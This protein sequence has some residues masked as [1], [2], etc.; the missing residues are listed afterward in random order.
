MRDDISLSE[1]YEVL[2]HL[3]TILCL[4]DIKRAVDGSW[5][6]K[7]YHK[8]DHA[9]HLLPAIRMMTTDFSDIVQKHV[10]KTTYNK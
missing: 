10:K 4:F 5:G 3:E 8:L 2:D 6:N 9:E 7:W 1:A